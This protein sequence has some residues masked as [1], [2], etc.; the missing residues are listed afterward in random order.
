[1]RPE[2]FKITDKIPNRKC[3]VVN[4]NLLQKFSPHKFM[5]SLQLIRENVN[6]QLSHFIWLCVKSSFVIFY[7]YK[8][9]NES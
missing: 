6:R 1:M 9:S 7:S 4:T 5:S 3:V 2:F 8:I